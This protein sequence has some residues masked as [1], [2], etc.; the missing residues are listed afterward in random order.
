[1][2][3]NL[4]S[5]NENGF[6]KPSISSVQIIENDIVELTIGLHKHIFDSNGKLLGSAEIQANYTINNHMSCAQPRQKF[7]CVPT[8]F[9]TED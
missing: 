4:I 1:M 3:A 7:N 9:K 6:H 2:E 8:N 5:Y